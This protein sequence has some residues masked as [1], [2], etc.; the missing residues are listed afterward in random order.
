[1]IHFD[2]ISLLLYFASSK[3][4]LVFCSSTSFARLPSFSNSKL[5]LYVKSKVY[6]PKSEDVGRCLKVE[7]T[8]VLN[9]AEF[10]PIFAVSLPVCPGISNNSLNIKNN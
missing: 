1:M 2:L 3:S 6:W 10:P 5:L 9:D 7:C 8:P 4:L